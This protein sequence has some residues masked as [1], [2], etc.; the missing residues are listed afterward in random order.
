MK[1]FWWLVLLLI[2]VL[3]TAC[4]PTQVTR[5][6]PIETRVTLF[7]LRDAN[8]NQCLR[9]EAQGKYDYVKVVSPRFCEGENLK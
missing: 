7:Y 1:K 5:T 2:V 9:F 8:T 6:T 3:T 4:E